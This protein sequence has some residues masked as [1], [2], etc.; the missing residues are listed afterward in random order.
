[1]THGGNQRLDEPIHNSIWLIIGHSDNRGF[2]FLHLTDCLANTCIVVP[3]DIEIDDCEG[4]RVFGEKRSCPFSIR[5]EICTKTFGLSG[6]LQG[7]GNFGI[8]HVYKH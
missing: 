6:L 1:M 5:A 8:R 4:R 2:I 7:F 3:S